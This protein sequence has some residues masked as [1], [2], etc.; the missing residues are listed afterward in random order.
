M[1]LIIYYLYLGEYI[2]LIK[3][4]NLSED[5]TQRRLL[6][7]SLTAQLVYAI[8]AV[9]AEKTASKPAERDIDY[10]DFRNRL[11]PRMEENYELYRSLLFLS[12]V[13]LISFESRAK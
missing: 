12:K 5:E 11:K 4:E 7:Q 13:G 9:M 6:N 1:H 10:I 3:M 8:L 2:V